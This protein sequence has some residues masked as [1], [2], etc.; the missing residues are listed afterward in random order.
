MTKRATAA[1]AIPCFGVDL[2]LFGLIM[3]QSPY[4]I[5]NL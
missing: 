5:I 4:K 3:M 1:T 2:I